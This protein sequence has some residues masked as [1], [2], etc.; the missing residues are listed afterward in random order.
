MH[1]PPE[2]NEAIVEGEDDQSIIDYGHTYYYDTGS[3][4]KDD[5][6]KPDPERKKL[7]RIQ[8]CAVFHKIAQGKGVPHTFVG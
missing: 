5:L 7:Q 2:Q 1:F 4:S 8:T 3:S 6:E